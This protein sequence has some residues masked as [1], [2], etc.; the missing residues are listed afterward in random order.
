MI[1]HFL[2]DVFLLE[3]KDDVLACVDWLDLSA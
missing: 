1:Q 3:P 2:E